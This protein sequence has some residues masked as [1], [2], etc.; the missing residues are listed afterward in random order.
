M[1]D[2]LEPG[3]GRFKVFEQLGATSDLDRL[4]A[5]TAEDA[6]S[7][8]ASIAGSERRAK[9]SREATHGLSAREIEVLRLVARGMTNE[10]IAIL[11]FL[12]ERTVDRHVSNIFTKIDVASRAAAT[13]FAYENGIA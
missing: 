10:A 5:D 6:A 13:A 7:A 4:P 3:T 11:L 1:R 12:S 8:P 9:R 2:S